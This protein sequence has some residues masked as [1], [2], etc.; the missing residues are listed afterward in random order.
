[1][2]FSV[3]VPIYNIAHYLPQCVESALAQ[4]EQDFELVLVDDG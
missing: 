3:L 4:S 2:L 1:M